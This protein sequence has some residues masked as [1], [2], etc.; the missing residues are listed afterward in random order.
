VAEPRF[1]NKGKTKKEANVG[2]DKGKSWMN[3]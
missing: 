1:K 2:I 3:S